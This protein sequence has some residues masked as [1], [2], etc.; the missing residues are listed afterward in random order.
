MLGLMQDQ[1]LLISSVLEHA[2]KAHPHTEIASRMADGSVHHCTYA[3]IGERAKQVANALVALGVQ[4]GERIGTLAW[5]G[6]RHM[7]LYFGVSGMGAVL[8]TINPR[9]FAEQIE[10]IANHAED[11]YLLFDLSFAELVEQIAPRLKTVKAF[12][13]LCDREQM[14]A[15][16]VLHLGH[17]WQSQGCAVFAPFFDPA[18]AGTV[19]LRWLRSIGGG[20]SV[21]GRADVPRQCLGYAVCRR[22][23][24]CQIGVAGRRT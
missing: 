22:N 4:P 21:V 6:Y 2:L 13:A 19:Y 5:N 20:F 3:D 17:H 23:V 24:W 8:H 14:P 18:F 7:E 9:L 1:P 12:I 16:N 11:Q 15:I 10:F